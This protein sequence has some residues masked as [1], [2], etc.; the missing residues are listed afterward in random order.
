MHQKCT[1][2]AFFEVTLKHQLHFFSSPLLV[3]QICLQAPLIW[4]STAWIAMRTH[5]WGNSPGT[6]QPLTGPTRTGLQ[7]SVSI[8]QSVNS[9]RLSRRSGPC[10][11][12]FHYLYL[13]ERAGSTSVILASLRWFS[14]KLG[15]TTTHPLDVN[16]SSLCTQHNRVPTIWPNQCYKVYTQVW[17]HRLKDWAAGFSS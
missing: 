2:F 14:R 3:F 16:L 12:A 7:S 8:L 15:S 11:W 6:N 10:L 13:K 9:I 17:G 4:L 5:C 1:V